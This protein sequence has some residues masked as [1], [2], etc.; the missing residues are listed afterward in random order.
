MG[1]IAILGGTG[2]EGLGL[3]MRFAMCGDTVVLGSRQNERA[4]A[5]AATARER[6]RAAGSPSAVSGSD[7]RGAI[8]G[9]E[10]VVV[11]TPFA[12][13][14]TLMPELASLLAGTIVIDVVNPLIR[15]DK[16]FTVETVPEGSAA[17]AL[18][19]LLPE[20]FVVSAFKNESAELLQ[21]LP[22][23]VHGDVLVCS[24]HVAARRRVLDLV[25]RIP[26][27]R[28]VDAGPLVN[29]RSIEA[30]TALLLNLNHRHHALTAVQIL[31]LPAD[32]IAGAAAPRA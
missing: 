9:A 18:Q 30:I 8:V 17:E 4:V 20:S 16:A 24:D 26:A 6:L 22:R 11:A 27:Y 7:N 5:A 19:Q 1:H 2:P 21:A 29:A 10:L 12:G 14:R 23:P 25:R 28:A 15:R 13:V 3:G 31:G 32:D